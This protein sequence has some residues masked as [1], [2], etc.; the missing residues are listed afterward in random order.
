MKALGWG[1]NSKAT[2]WNVY[3]VNDYKVHTKTW[4]DDKKITYCDVHV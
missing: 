3:F 4:N 2:S 1:P